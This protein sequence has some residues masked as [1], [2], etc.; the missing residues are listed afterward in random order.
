MEQ[1]AKS[2][3]FTK[4]FFKQF[5][6]SKD[7]LVS[8]E[9]NAPVLEAAQQM[10]KHHVGNIVVTDSKAGKKKAVGIVTDR[11]LTIAGLARN[12][13]P[14]T[15]TVQEVMN[16]SLTT[17]TENEEI[18]SMIAKMKENGVNRLPILNSSG[19]VMG[20]VTS[21]KLVQVLVQGL[22][23]LSALSIQQHQKEN[24]LLRH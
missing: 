10:L 18:F 3:P 9:A 14:K 4:D 11:D 7:Q 2:S 24:E 1:T 13:D 6:V 23:E 20:I 5:A 22:Q 21:K 17:V 16:K 15:T 19:E 8:I 12:L